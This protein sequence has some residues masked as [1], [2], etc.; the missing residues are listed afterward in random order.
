[1]PMSVGFVNETTT[2]HFT[3]IICLLLF[4]LQSGDLAEEVSTIIDPPYADG[5]DI[6]EVQVLLT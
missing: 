3:R 4:F 5:V 2:W 6:S 1:M